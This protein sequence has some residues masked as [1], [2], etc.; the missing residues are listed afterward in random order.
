MIRNTIFSQ[1]D[2]VTLVG[3]NFMFGVEVGLCLSVG[4]EVASYDTIELPPPLPPF[5]YPK[6]CL[7]IY[8]KI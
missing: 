5:P 6:F 4:V 7:N 1:D 8:E 3:I 2:S